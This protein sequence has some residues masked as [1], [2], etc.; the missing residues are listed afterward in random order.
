MLI[1]Q[2]S[3]T[4]FLNQSLSTIISVS[5]SKTDPVSAHTWCKS[6]F[7]G[8]PILVRSLVGVQKI[9]SFLLQLRLAYLLP[10]KFILPHFCF[11]THTHTHSLTYTHTHTH[12]YI[13]IGMISSVKYKLVISELPLHVLKE[14][15]ESKVRSRKFYE[16]CV[17]T[18][19]SRFLNCER[20]IRHRSLTD[21][22]YICFLTRH[23]G[24]RWTG[25]KGVL[26]D[27]NL[28]KRKMCWE[29]IILHIYFEN[30]SHKLTYV[31]FINV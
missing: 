2:I 6:L 29:H 24:I 8:W 22:K 14:R 23:N 20:A 26:K 5:S 17:K 9:T 27:I 16:K 18:R 3:L 4:L 31:Y 21:M 25:G 19:I 30:G 28:C 1:A 10:F 7:A 12:T 11:H 15:K 13:Y